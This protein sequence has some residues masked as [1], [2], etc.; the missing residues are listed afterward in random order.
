MNKECENINIQHIV[1]ERSRD[2][3]ISCAELFKI[4]N[5][6]TVF[7]DILGQCV[8]LEKLKISHCQLGLF[9]YENKKKIIEPAETVTEELENKIYYLLEEGVLPCAAAWVI[10]DELEI[11]RLAVAAACE[12]MKIKIKKCQLGAFK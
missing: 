11:P 6:Y 3:Y 9:G 10:A 5:E 2:G 12:K 7:P 8:N 4:V 1:K